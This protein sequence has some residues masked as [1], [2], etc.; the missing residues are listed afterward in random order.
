MSNKTSGPLLGIHLNVYKVLNSIFPENPFVVWQPYHPS[1]Q[2]NKNYDDNQTK[3]TLGMNLSSSL[4][5]NFAITVKNEK[6]FCNFTPRYEFL[7]KLTCFV[8]IHMEKK[9]TRKIGEVFSVS[10]YFCRTMEPSGLTYRWWSSAYM[11]IEIVLT[12]SSS[13]SLS[14]SCSFRSLNIHPP[15]MCSVWYRFTH[16]THRARDAHTYYT[17]SLIIH[18]DVRLLCLKLPIRY[19]ARSTTHT[20]THR[21][22]RLRDWR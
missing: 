10:H 8:L 14:R 5:C 2:L 20:H 12:P 3:K 6:N 1:S 19:D 9:L 15:F 16:H 7:I 22:L 21:V 13:F 11:H 4:F 17:H 18:T